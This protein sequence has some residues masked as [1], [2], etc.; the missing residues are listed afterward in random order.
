MSKFEKALSESFSG[1]GKVTGKNRWMARIIKV[2]T[3]AT[4]VYTENALAT[5]PL[6]FPAGTKVN[7]DHPSESEKWERPSGSV[8][9]L[10]GALISDPVVENGEAFAEIEFSQEAAP[11]VEQF[12]QVLG[13]SIRASGYGEEYNDVGLPI[14]E[15]FIPS[16]LNTVDLVTVAGAGGTLLSLM[17]SYVES[18]D[19]IN[20]EEANNPDGRKDGMTPDEIKALLAEVK[21]EI[22]AALKPEPVVEEGPSP[23]AISE[24]LIAANLPKSAREKVYTAVKGGQKLE[25]AIASEQAYIKELTE[26]FTDP[27]GDQGKVGNEA[28][29]DFMVGGWA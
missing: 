13:L 14:V 1:L 21:D 16:P 24:A 9:S 22:L 18:R 17:E 23:S 12:H 26:A 6:A 2:G 19:K 27:K 5:V 15:G 28:S 25:E 29:Y 3:G 20:S 11:F 10:A 7:F 8:T 4:G